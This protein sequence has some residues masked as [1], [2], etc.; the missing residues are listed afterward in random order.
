MKA[1]FHKP[2]ALLLAAGLLLSGLF[3]SAPA[4]AFAASGDTTVYVTRTG[5]K[6]HRSGCSYLR[7][8]KIAVSL[9]SAVG[10]GYTA[11]SRCNPPALS[12]PS[13]AAPS[14]T[15]QPSGGAAQTP[16]A[17]TPAAQT[18]VPGTP[19]AQASTV[20]TP[21]AAS[22][23]EIAAA[24]QAQYLQT[25]TALAS[26]GQTPDELLTQRVLLITQLYT[27]PA[28]QMLAQINQ[29]VTVQT[30]LNALGYGTLELNGLADTPT[31]LALIAFQQA[32]GLSTA[33]GLDSATL[34]AL[35][36]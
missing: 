2:M 32:A 30:Q 3:W 16:A 5:E 7:K 25:W 9:S 21:L 15:A 17:Q 29:L 12:A 19:A 11:C 23:A 22:P 14:V 4:V 24:L 31:M 28:D 35:G 36:A 26:A 13:A 10:G 18:P 34:A 27:L 8:S 20:Q 1:S 33:S 6:Y